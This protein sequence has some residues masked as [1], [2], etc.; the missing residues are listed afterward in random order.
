[1]ELGQ[2]HRQRSNIALM[3][4]LSG[5]L[6]LCPTLSYPVLS[7]PHTPRLIRDTMLPITR[8]SSRRGSS[9]AGVDVPITSEQEATLR[10]LLQRGGASVFNDFS[11]GG[12][13]PTPAGPRRDHLTQACFQALLDN[14][15]GPV[16][17]STAH[18]TAPSNGDE[19][20]DTVTHLVQSCVDALG[21]LNHSATVTPKLESEV[22]HVLNAASAVISLRHRQHALK[23]YPHLVTCV[24]SSS[25]KVR[26]A[27]Q[28]A[29]LKYEGLLK[30]SSS[31]HL[32]MTT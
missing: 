29:L 1:M 4:M 2:L 32:G 31:A 5:K 18:G 11:S 10:A 25:A 26:Q 22:T 16:D 27:L 24:A 23:L 19:P 15:G 20:S 8:Q 9:S 12:G 7:L 30:A 3:L 13:G 28:T 17:S 6:W 21:K 14:E